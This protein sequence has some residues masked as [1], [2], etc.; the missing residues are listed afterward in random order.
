MGLTLVFARLN[1]TTP[2]RQITAPTSARLAD[3]R[4]LAG[5]LRLPAGFWDVAH[6]WYLQGFV[7]AGG[8]A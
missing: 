4:K 6:A 1:D 7:H 2:E 5:P 3:E 8:N